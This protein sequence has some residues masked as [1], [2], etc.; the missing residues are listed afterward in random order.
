MSRPFDPVCF[1][2]FLTLLGRPDPG[3][4][5]RR[6]HVLRCAG[7][8]NRRAAQFP[9]ILLGWVQQRLVVKEFDREELLGWATQRSQPR[10]QPKDAAPARFFGRAAGA[11]V[12]DEMT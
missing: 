12:T 9:P 4:L 2:A 7:D 11:L 1:D 10:A 5:P 6:A 8:P 3:D